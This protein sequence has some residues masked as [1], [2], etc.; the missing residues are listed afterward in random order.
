MALLE[1]VLRPNAVM[2]GIAEKTTSLVRWLE[3]ADS[4]GQTAA[5]AAGTTCSVNLCS[6]LYAKFVADI[7][8]PTLCVAVKE[9]T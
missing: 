2:T 3:S 6:Q 4:G 1:R 9:E 5:A 8:I 7:L